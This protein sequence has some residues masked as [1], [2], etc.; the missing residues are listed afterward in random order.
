MMDPGETHQQ[1]GEYRGQRFLVEARQEGEVWIGHFRLIGPSEPPATE[2]P[3]AARWT[4][5]DPG[6]ATDREAIRNATEAAHAAV[7]AAL[8]VRKG[9]SI[10][11]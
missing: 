9:G 10:Q 1:F 6:W 3:G 4:P 11:A 7:D 2:A 5:L 8:S